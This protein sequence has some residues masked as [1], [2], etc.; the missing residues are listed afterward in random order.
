M[1]N[2]KKKKVTKENGNKKQKEGERVKRMEGKGFCNGKGLSKKVLETVI[3]KT[4]FTSIMGFA[5]NARYQ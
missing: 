2:G 5:L 4:C 3:K 1:N